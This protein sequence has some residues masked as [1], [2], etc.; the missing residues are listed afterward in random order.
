MH[1]DLMPTAPLER[2]LE[3]LTCSILLS[4]S[5]LRDLFKQPSHTMRPLDKLIV[6]AAEVLISTQ[7]L[8]VRVMK[9]TTPMMKKILKPL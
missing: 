2:Q 5:M 6:V 3:F 4:K 1:A 7:S 9:K 8:V